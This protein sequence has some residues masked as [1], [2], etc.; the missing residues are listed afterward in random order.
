MARVIVWDP[1]K[2]VTKGRVWR[3][4]R[5]GRDWTEFVRYMNSKYQPHQGKQE[6]ERRMRC[7]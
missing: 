5:T 7:D 3:R 4:V 2:M 6:C 1:P